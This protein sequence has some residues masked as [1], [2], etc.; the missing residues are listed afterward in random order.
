M[1]DALA[2]ALALPGFGWLVAAAIIAGLVRGF[3]GF[4]TAMIFLPIA[5]QFLGPFAAITALI[6]MDLIG[7]I[8]AL[9]R[10]LRD[11]SPRDL[12]RLLIGA[13]VGLPLGVLLLSQMGEEGFR[14]AVSGL[15]LGLLLALISGLRYRG[16]LTRRLLVGTGGISGLLGGAAGLPGP[17]VIMLYMTSTQPPAVIRGTTMAY[18]LFADI[19][20]IAVLALAGELVPSALTT[21]ALLILP[22]LAAIRLG[23][24]M[25]V[26]ERDALYRWVAYSVIAASAL[27]GLPIWDGLLG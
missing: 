22:Y 12:S 9:P 16:A 15:T 3:S 19:A 23:T 6:I 11:A 20:I 26:P 17:P 4:G 10:A 1:P 21:G 25:F 5:G 24:L 7:P 13:L 18:L 14:Y 8:P 2:T 27:S